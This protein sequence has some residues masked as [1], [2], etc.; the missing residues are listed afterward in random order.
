MTILEA[1]EKSDQFINGELV[2]SKGY[3]GVIDPVYD[4]STIDVI[5][6]VVRVL[7]E[8][9]KANRRGEFVCNRCHLRKTAESSCD[10]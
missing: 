1:L 4:K 10:F 2:W 3:Y 5:C 9:V 7:S 6:E 8:E